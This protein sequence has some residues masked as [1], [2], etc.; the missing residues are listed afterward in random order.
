MSNTNWPR[1]KEILDKSL[2]RWKA[3]NG[4]E[5]KMKA[6][7]EGSIGWGSKEELAQSHPYDKQLIESDKVGNGR[8]EETN[9]VKILRRN[10]GGFRRMPSRGPYLP[11]EEIR[12]IAEWIDAGMPD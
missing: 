3:E 5:A 7:H 9:L 2:E 4:R 12:E 8:A 6:V 10:I 11:N 1:I